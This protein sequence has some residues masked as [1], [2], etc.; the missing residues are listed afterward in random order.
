[1]LLLL[2]LCCTMGVQGTNFWPAGLMQANPAAKPTIGLGPYNTIIAAFTA[3]LA[4]TCCGVCLW[5]R[6]L[7]AAVPQE[8]QEGQQQEREHRSVDADVSVCCDGQAGV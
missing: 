7:R 2:L 1:L 6:R 8:Q 3:V 5:Q 4:S